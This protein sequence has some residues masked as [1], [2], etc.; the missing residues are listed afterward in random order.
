[1]D[2]TDD[3]KAFAT[4]LAPMRKPYAKPQIPPRTAIQ[5]YSVNA[6]VMDWI[7]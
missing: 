7:C 2:D 3:A 6:M 4:S 5:R 1:L